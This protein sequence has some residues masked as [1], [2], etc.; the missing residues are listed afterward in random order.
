[1]D[2]QPF[3]EPPLMGAAFTP[4]SLDTLFACFAHL[5]AEALRL[6]VREGSKFL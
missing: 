4:G 5:P 6:H 1:M 3:F 2:G